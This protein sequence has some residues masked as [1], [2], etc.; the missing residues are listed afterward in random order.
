MNFNTLLLLA[1]AWL[2]WTIHQDLTESNDRQRSLKTTM[3]QL[4]SRLEQL[5]GTRDALSDSAAQA[6]ATV[7]INTA[8]KAKLQ[9]LPRIGAVTAEHII[10]ARPYSAIE[11]LRQVQGVTNAIFSEINDRVSV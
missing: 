5:L 8:S 2:L 6:A 10:A 11:D 4:A 9:T 3:T 1:I 7:N